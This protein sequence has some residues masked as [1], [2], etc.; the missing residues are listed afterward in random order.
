MVL[1]EILVLTSVALCGRH[2]LPPGQGGLGHAGRGGSRGDG[3]GHPLDHQ[4]KHETRARESAVQSP[5]L[6]RKKTFSARFVILFENARLRFFLKMRGCA[7]PHR[8]P[9]FL[10]AASSQPVAVSSCRTTITTCYAYRVEAVPS[11]VPGLPHAMRIE[12]RQVTTLEKALPYT[13][14]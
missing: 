8:R 7:R 10:Y 5:R 11:S 14:R 4:I 2:R 9:A 13:L 1:P 3:T 12:L 6:G